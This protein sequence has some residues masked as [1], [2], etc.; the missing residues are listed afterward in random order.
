MYRLQVRKKD[1]RATQVIE[2][3]QEFAEMVFSVMTWFNLKD[4]NRCDLKKHEAFLMEHLE[5][6]SNNADASALKR[7]MQRYEHVTLLR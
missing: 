6:M 5:V 7:I 4:P 1:S 2:M 3:N